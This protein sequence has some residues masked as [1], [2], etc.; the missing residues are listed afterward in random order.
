[1]SLTLRTQTHLSS[2]LTLLLSCILTPPLSAILLLIPPV[3]WAVFLFLVCQGNRSSASLFSL[4]VLW[5][6]SQLLCDSCCHREKNEKKKMLNCIS[7]LE[8]NLGVTFSSVY[9][10]PVNWPSS[11]SLYGSNARE[12]TTS[13]GDLSILGP[14]RPFRKTSLCWPKICAH[15]PLFGHSSA[16]SNGKAWVYFFLPR[17]SSL[18]PLSWF[19]C[20]HALK[21]HGSFPNSCVCLISKLFNPFNESGPALPTTK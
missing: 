8:R 1:M 3:F 12:L 2:S 13:Q 17:G 15:F 18:D 11:F 5:H 6:Q 20:F 10:I 14:C 4:C 19:S 16:I 7:S 9:S 21:V